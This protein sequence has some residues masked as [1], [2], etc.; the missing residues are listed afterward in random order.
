MVQERGLGLSSR[1][2]N[3]IN[4]HSVE[5]PYKKYDITKPPPSPSSFTSCRL[6]LLRRFYSSDIGEV[7]LSRLLARRETLTL[8][9]RE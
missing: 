3:Y 6:L 4:H 9:I 5:V 8:Y 7:F 1:K 2:R